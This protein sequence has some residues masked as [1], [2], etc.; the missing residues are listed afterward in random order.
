MSPTRKSTLQYLATAAA[1]GCLPTATRA[2]ARWLHRPS[3]VRAPCNAHHRCGQLQL[4]PLTSS[5]PRWPFRLQH[6]LFG[7]SFASSQSNQRSR[8]V[9]PEPAD[10]QHSLH[11]NVHYIIKRIPIGRMH[12]D[13]MQ[14]ARAFLSIVSK[15]RNEQGATLAEA[16]LERLYKEQTARRDT[17]VLVDSE[18]YNICMDAWNQSGADGSKIVE[19]VESMIHRVE[20]RY[21]R[22]SE[23]AADSV[24][25]LA[26]PD[27]FS[28][29][30]LINAYSKCD[31]DS[32][33]KVEGVLEKMYAFAREADD[34]YQSLIRP[35]K[36]T[37]NSLINYYASRQNDPLA[38]QRAEDLLLQMSE[39]SQQGEDTRMDATSFNTVLKAWSNSGGGINAAKRA[40]TVLRMMIKYVPDAVGF[41]TVI[42][43]YAKVDPEDASTGVENTMSLLDE[44]EGLHFD[45]DANVASC[46]SAAAHVV[47]KS[48]LHGAAD[49]VKELMDRMRN[50]DATPDLNMYVSLVEA[51]ANEGSDESISQGKELLL[52]VIG[53][54]ELEPSV[55]P[56]NILLNAM[57]KGSSPNK[58]EQAEQLMATMESVG[59]NARPDVATYNVFISELSRSRSQGKAQKAVDQLRDMLKAY[60]GGYEAAKP[61]SFVF[62]CVIGMLSRSKPQDWAENT[63]YR[64]LMAMESQRKRGNTDVV[65]DTI[66]Y[67]IV[68][69]K[70]A[71]SPTK[72]NAKKVTKLLVDM[73]ESAKSDGTIAP[74]IIT[75]TNVLRIQAKVSPLRAAHLA[76]SCLER[77]TAKEKSMPIDRAGF[78]AL[79]LALSK[80]HKI[81]HATMAGKAWEWMEDP[82]RV[83]TLDSGLCNLVLIAYSNAKDRRAA[84]EALAFLAE[85]M[86]RYRDGDKSTILPTLVGFGAATATL[87]K[88]G[89]IEDALRVLESMK[90]LS[91]EGV[92]NIKP[93][94]GCYA[95]ILGPL[96]RSGSEN[97]PLQALT[98]F[99]QMKE[100]LGI[101]PTAPLNA[102]IS[103]CA[104]TGGQRAIEAAFELLRL[105]RESDS[106]DAD[107]FGLVIRTCMSTGDDGTKFRLV[108]PLFKLCA[109]NGL[110]GRR[111][112]AEI[113]HFKKRLLPNNQLPAEWTANVGD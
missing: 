69:G 43:A 106:V 6:R 24:H 56:F 30:S 22:G 16:L 45:A 34:D 35:D 13:N 32:L 96:A 64:T 31:D 92:P 76:A 53:G 83:H 68:I 103:A 27:K 58:I 40:E 57:L 67:N 91:G 23:D 77:A 49:R 11:S 48:G 112:L 102:A 1:R 107:S 105:G 2:Y 9:A 90:A 66:A 12:D 37:Y 14:K 113:K 36:V 63:I 7:G 79:L 72:E 41:A 95:S 109:K 39:R 104:R 87:S 108:E 59:G 98:V 85:R 33:D 42:R 73:E 65:P 55:I 18:M 10:E 89:K 86:R 8:G 5:Y 101:L 25:H 20:E 50:M 51:Y 80:S 81:E 97:A 99:R 54:Q 3:T 93:D 47:A 71:Q 84:D 82:A 70:L 60:S 62:N 52:D 15:W 75:Y 46:Y 88:A 111:V 44:L 94:V 29:N 110:V 28:Y 74:D 78:L 61:T 38:A 19:R 26:R 4:P 100:D 17:D 21:F